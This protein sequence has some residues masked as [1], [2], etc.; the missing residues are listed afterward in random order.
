MYVLLCEYELL[1]KSYGLVGA[2]CFQDLLQQ[3]KVLLSYI[4]TLYW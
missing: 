1:H 3:L 4:H 2:V